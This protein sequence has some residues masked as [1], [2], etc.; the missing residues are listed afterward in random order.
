MG[1][2]REQA[3][4][5]KK[6]PVTIVLDDDPTGTQSVSGV[7]VLVKPDYEAIR[8]QLAAGPQ[9][10]ALYALTN[11]RALPRDEAIA[12]VRRIKADAERAASETGTAVRFLLRGDS[13]LRGH[14]FAEIEALG[15]NGPA[16]F[17]PAFPECGRV[18]RDGVHYLVTGETWKPVAETEFARDP[19]F[20]YRS[21]T[22]EDWVQEASGG[23]WRLKTVTERDYAASTGIADAIRLALREAGPGVV[24]IPD[25]GSYEELCQVAEGLRLAEAD[26]AEVVVRSASTF[27]SIRCGLKPLELDRAD[28]PANGRLL[29][30][31]GSHTEAA[32]R[33]L[34]Q[35]ER[36]TGEKP[37]VL[38][39]K[40]LLQGEQS[41]VVS[42][43]AARAATRL[44]DGK[45][46][47][48][49]TERIR[50]AE[51]GDLAVG[52]LV[53]KALTEVV[54][55]L[56]PH[57]DGVISKGGITSADVA[58]VGLGA[59]SAYVAG[60]LEPGISL[61]RLKPKCQRRQGGSGSGSGSEREIPYCIVPGNVGDDGTLARLVR[62]Y[63][64][65][66]G[67]SL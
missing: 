34:E 46:A 41:D 40:R 7:T 42:E 52:A 3:D 63:K 53:M 38:P 4:F 51:H 20:G 13:T 36:D 39:V 49:A 67:A 27:A 14:V 50:L 55:K 61:W 6:A 59:D 48:L 25:A 37:I 16:L 29:V 43:I 28:M 22:L 10:H 56:A 33:Q 44:N 17:V 66:G 60:Q 54:R 12:L 2:K 32:S 64:R 62:I 30:V 65:T 18:T 35:L 31:C 5:E 23:S 47:I 19:V 9:G 21:A 1:E 11:T 24:V 15:G 58:S 8:E 26:G 57:C 45:L